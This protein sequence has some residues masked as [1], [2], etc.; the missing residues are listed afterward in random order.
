MD[1]WYERLSTLDSL[2]LEIED[3]SAHMHVGA[4]AIFEGPPPPYRDFLAL[5][6][7]RL[8][9]VPRYR[10]RVMFV[11]L[12]QGRPV[13]ID[14]TQF[15]LEYHV[16]HTALPAPGGEAELKKLVGRLFSQALD[17]DKPLWEMWLVEGLGES[18]FAIVSKTHHCM[19]DGISGVDLATVLMDRKPESAPP[20][21]PPSWQPRKAPR[22]A[23]LL[24]SSVKEQLSSPLRMAREALEPNSEAAKLVARLFSGFKPF[25]DVVSMGRAP[26]SPLNVAIGP[27]R[28]FEMV[29]IPLAKVKAVRA[30]RGGT[31]N[32]VILATVAGALRIW[33]TA[34]GAAA[35]AD[36]R[37][38]VPVSMRSRKERGTYGN[39]VSAVFCP[40]PLTEASPTERLRKV[41]EAMMNV[42]KSGSAVGAHALSRLG[43][44]A[45]PQLIAQA[46][47]LQAVT[48]MFNLVVTNVPGPQF[49][50]YLLGRQMLRCY[51]QVPLAA[52][53]AVGIALLS[54][55]GEVGAGLL[56]DAD[57]ARDLP[58][59]AQAM[60]TA[61]DELHAA[62]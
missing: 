32:D 27:H 30:A 62:V 15:D 8:E 50:L 55:H 16:R 34:R 56:G 37:V 5:I 46:A 22:P 36:L 2:F 40:L 18:R 17:R 23:A 47:R 7:A 24:F 38:L 54:Y 51:P 13:W 6:E 21:K 42:K 26:E 3:R 10:Q 49:P 4:V 31:V 20:P 25:V 1:T 45:P 11:P 52:Q 29:D 14:E 39:Q 58:A 9:K 35:A 28:R 43:D 12:K 61:L 53:Q 57:A 41:H 33:L 19:L 44:F 48:R 59:L 60:H